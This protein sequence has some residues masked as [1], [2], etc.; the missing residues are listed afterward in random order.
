MFN[1]TETTCRL[2]K[3]PKHDVFSLVILTFDLDIQN[4]PCEGPNTSSM[5]IWHKSI[6]SSRDISYTN[7]K[8]TDSAKNRTL[9]SSLRVVTNLVRQ[10]GIGAMLHKKTHNISVTFLYCPVQSTHAN[11]SV[12]HTHTNTCA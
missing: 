1:Q 8:V 5:W 9:C 7:K 2:T 6:Q 10:S 4:C 11:L 12:T 3:G